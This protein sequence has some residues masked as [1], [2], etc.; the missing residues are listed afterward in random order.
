[1]SAT[2]LLKELPMLPDF[3]LAR[4]QG[5]FQDKVLLVRLDAIGD[6]VLFRNF[7]PLISRHYGLKMALCGNSAWRS[8]AESFDAGLVENFIW[9]DRNRMA[10]DPGYRKSRLAEI[11]SKGYRAL[12]HPTFSRDLLADF[13]VRAV[14]AKEKTGSVGD[15][16][17]TGAFKKWLTDSFYSRL[18][19]ASGKVLFE[20][21]RNREFVEALTGKK[22]GLKKPTLDVSKIRFSSG[23]EKGKFVVLFPGAT[24][25]MRRWS[26]QKFA[27]LATR[28][29][30]RHGLGIVVAGS[31]G[32]AALAR[33]VSEGAPGARVIDATGKTSLP[34]LARLIHDSALLVSNDTS[35]V[36]L[37]AAVGTKVACI[38]NRN[39]PGR[40]V[41]YP[42]D[43]FNGMRT[44]YPGGRIAD[45]REFAG[46]P[47]GDC[48]R[49]F[50]DVNA[51][52]VEQVEAAVESL[53]S[54][55]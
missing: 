50:L 42:R 29:G 37:A 46:L 14:G 26:P 7:I 24:D 22:A 19:P 54:A 45:A 20:F 48:K 4:R 13:I 51:I 55:R 34:E 6:Y 27:K 40:F 12:V 11:T 2:G 43:V 18:L 35:A 52:T 31:A 1:V 36:H 28:M 41:P 3:L 15:A 30:K 8:L 23:A 9:V 5:P 38:S 49:S 53:L 16:T 17:N 33:Q 39:Y 25:A 44:V 21:Y 47:V 10:G 32:D